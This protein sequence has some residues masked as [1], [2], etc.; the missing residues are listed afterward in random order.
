[1]ID[2]ISQSGDEIH[3][4]LAPV[5]LGGGVRLFDDLGAGRSRLNARGSSKRP[6]SPTCF[7]GS[8]SNRRL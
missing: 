1:M 7:S 6:A 2:D 5:L 4:D 8:S 3:I